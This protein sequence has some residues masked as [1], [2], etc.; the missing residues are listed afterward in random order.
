MRRQMPGALVERE[1]SV[2]SRAQPCKICGAEDTCTFGFD[3][4][5]ACCAAIPS[6]WPLVTGGWLHRLPSDATDTLA[7]PVRTRE[8]IPGRATAVS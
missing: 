7:Q 3:E 2:V 5:F 8:P 1:W 6:E 4:E